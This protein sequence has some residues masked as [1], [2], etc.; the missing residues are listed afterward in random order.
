MADR[1]FDPRPANRVVIPLRWLGVAVAAV[2]AAIGA[3]L[4]FWQRLP[5]QYVIF[6]AAATFALVLWIWTAFLINWIAEAAASSA[7]AAARAGGTGSAREALRRFTTRNKGVLGGLA[8]LIV[9]FVILS[10]AW[11]G[12]FSLLNLITALVLAAAL[13]LTVII[14]RAFVDNR[15]AFIGLMVLAVLFAVASLHIQGFLS[16]ANVKSMLV[17]ASFLGLAS[18]GQT[19]VALARRP[20]PLDSLS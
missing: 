15:S 17:F 1:A 11:T 13:I 18:V 16:W 12:F 2:I 19:L 20:R 7:A 8:L 3:G 9:G 4:G 14:S 6:C 5:A 10:I